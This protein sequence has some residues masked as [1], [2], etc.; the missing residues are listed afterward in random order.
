MG[1]LRS[2][3]R[4]RLVCSA[5]FFLSLSFSLRYD[6]QGLEGT[7]ERERERW[8]NGNRKQRFVGSFA[9]DRDQGDT[10]IRRTNNRISLFTFRYFTR[11]QKEISSHCESIGI[12][13]TLVLHLYSLHVRDI[14]S[15]YLHLLFSLSH[16]LS[17]SFYIYICLSY[18]E[19][20]SAIS[21][22][23]TELPYSTN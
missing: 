17:R 7:R 20:D 19:L 12:V 1:Q 2:F 22:F 21:E 13:R 10:R 16:S 5:S 4:R 3:S 14:F 8:Y 6:D 9:E 18:D 11:G 23:Q 15:L